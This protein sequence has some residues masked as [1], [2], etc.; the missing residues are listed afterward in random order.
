V[1]GHLRLAAAVC[2]AFSAPGCARPD[3]MPAPI[4]AESDP[5]GEGGGG[6]GGGPDPGR[7]GADA[8]V[9]VSPDAPLAIPADGG[10]PVPDAPGPQSPCRFAFCEGFEAYPD[11]QPPD[12]TLWE[13][14]ATKAVVDGMHAAHGSKALHVGPLLKDSIV[15]R[16]S[17]TFP[18]LGKAFYARVRLWIEK[19][20]VERPPNL[21][22]WTLIEASDLPAGGGRRVRLG[23][24]I[25]ARFPGDWLRFNY[26]TGAA[27]TPH[28]TGLSDKGALVPPR[29]WHCIEIYF[30]MDRQEARVWL[31]GEERTALHWLD[32]MPRMPLF[33]FPPEIKSLSFGW[34]EY[35]PPETPFEVW[36]DDIA[37][38]GQRIG[39]D[40]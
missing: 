33:K 23:G 11:G 13:Q 18:A 5:V 20:P 4:D 12:P 30:D 21:Y 15:I 39:C 37:V 14:K 27:T 7:A 38:D 6:G 29:R 8:A 32:S 2:L 36:L 9:I 26:E 19:E 28:E 22:H 1:T 34:T 24:H 31:N 40:E 3:A 10:P 17:R 16:E 25:E 35:Q